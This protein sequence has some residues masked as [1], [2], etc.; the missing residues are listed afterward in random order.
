M[1]R[2]LFVRTSVVAAA[3][4]LF[5]PVAFA[6]SPGDNVEGVVTHV[7][8]HDSPRH[9]V[10]RSGGEE[11]KVNITNRTNVEFPAVDKGYFSEELSSLKSG[12]TVRTTYN[13]DQPAS[14]VVVTSVPPAQRREA[15]NTFEANRSG[16]SAR[17]ADERGDM[18]VRLTSV[19]QSRGE[20]RADFKGQER[21]FRVEDPKMLSRF[22][23]GDM[24]VVT[25]RDGSSRDLV[26][27]DIRSAN[28][29]GRVVDIDRSAGKVRVTVDGREETFKADR[30]K[31]LQLKEGD[32]ISFEVEERPN[33]ERVITKI[34][35][36]N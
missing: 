17:A 16:S 19:N 15:I 10:V 29:F 33:G 21:S 11:V 23:E 12:M 3:A 25:V 31:A 26:V 2:T 5:V 6:V 24:V 30:I 34:D 27:T 35:E 7:E 32:R 20:F 8:L 14:R 1:L 28:L 4:W 36:R 9:I 18:K 22:D 13:G